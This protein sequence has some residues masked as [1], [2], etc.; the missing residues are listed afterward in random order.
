MFTFIVHYIFEYK[1]NNRKDINTVFRKLNF[2]R[3]ELGEFPTQPGSG[4]VENLAGRIGSGHRKW[5][6]P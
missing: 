2:W 5:T 4:W 3:H 1:F 6:D